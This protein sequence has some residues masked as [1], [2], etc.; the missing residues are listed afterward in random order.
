MDTV[1]G[2]PINA[3][4]WFLDFIGS[5]MII[6]VEKYLGTTLEAL[7]TNTIEVANTKKWKNVEIPF[8]LTD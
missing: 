2:D 6:L 4:K 1:V 8:F 7:C 3:I 5:C